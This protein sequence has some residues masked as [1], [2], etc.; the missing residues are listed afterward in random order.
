MYSDQ[1][2]IE[3]VDI[4]RSEGA[5]TEWL[6]FKS[7]QVSNQD[8][9]EYISALSNGAALWGR[10]YA[11]LIF[12]VDDK[13]H[14]VVGTTFDYRKTKQGNEDVENW[15]N[16]LVEPKIG[17]NFYE[18]NYAALKKLV[19]VEIRAANKQPTSFAG[20]E[21]I[22]IGSYRQDLR[23]Y[24]ETERKLWNELNHVLWE[25][26][27]SPV[28][29]LH[30]KNMKTIADSKDIDFSPEKYA[31]LHMVD[32]NGKFTNLAY[33][34]S[35]ENSHIIKF[36]VYRNKMYDFAVKKEFSGGWLYALDQVLDYVNLFNDT[37][38][39]VIGSDATRTEVK[40]YPDPSLR[41]A[42]VNAFAHF[43]PS[44]P[45][46]IKIEFFPDKVVIGSPGSLYRTTMKA[47]LSGR[48][49][50][51]NPN[52]VYVMNK[53]DYI[54][55]Y[56]TGLQKILSVYSKYPAQP[57]LEPMDNF[58]VVTLPNVKVGTQDENYFDATNGTVN[59]TENDTV[60][61]TVSDTL[62][63]TESTVLKTIKRNAGVTISDLMKV[64]EKSRP[65]IARA[66]AELKAKGYI[67]RVGSDKKGFWKVLK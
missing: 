28:Q 60:N 33:L 29:N 52:L 22:R 30:F 24:P 20:K 63:D 15:L 27:L 55:N 13:T 36:A 56:A 8:I 50:F 2:L 16:R 40:N 32:E 64:L 21:Y 34:L 31:T 5:E 51:R 14:E 58:F 67:E 23:K 38:A 1:E 37:S 54:E 65:T 9:G 12:G 41:E 44:F 35:D 18:V 26:M 25:E 42:V 48:Q 61:D 45:S 53:F 62:N 4:L 66:L 47:V 3:L 39:R 17:F 59:D 6:E 19:L 11:Y 46:D 49:S 7:N 57:I 43:D 10:P